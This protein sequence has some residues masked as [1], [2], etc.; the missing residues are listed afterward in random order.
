MGI[1]KAI[2]FQCE[3]KGHFLPSTPNTPK[4]EFEYFKDSVVGFTPQDALMTWFGQMYD[5][6]C[7][8]HF[9]KE[10]QADETRSLQEFLSSQIACFNIEDDLDNQ[11]TMTVNIPSFNDQVEYEFTVFTK[12]KE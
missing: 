5:M 9:N 4:E 10:L 11:L 1:T 12:V 8:F 2:V 6:H 7:N 3:F